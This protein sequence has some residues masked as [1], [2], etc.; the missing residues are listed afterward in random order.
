MA[1]GSAILMLLVT[2]CDSLNWNLVVLL[3]G[4]LSGIA[5]TNDGDDYTLFILVRITRALKKHSPNDE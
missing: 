3:L 5:N 1:E 4:L 2:C